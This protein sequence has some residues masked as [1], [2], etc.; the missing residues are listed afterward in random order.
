MHGNTYLMYRWTAVSADAVSAVSVIRSWPRP[1]KN[2]GKLR[3]QTFISFK[4]RQART[5]RNMVKSNNPNAPSTWL[6]FLCPRT[7]ASPQ[8][9]QHSASSVLAVQNTVVAALPQCLCSESPCGGRHWLGHPPNHDILSSIHY[10]LINTDSSCECKWEPKSGVSVWRETY[11]V[12]VQCSVQYTVNVQCSVQCAVN[13]QCNV[14]YTVNV[15]GSVQYTVNV[16]GS[17]QYA[18]NVQCSVQDAVNYNAVYS[19][20]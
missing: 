17:V 13:V 2:L 20:L 11:T 14:Q 12:N 18:V 5:G 8:T 1:E 6:I 9:Y 10:N 16:Q 19:T 7:H 4:R 3:K 15:Q